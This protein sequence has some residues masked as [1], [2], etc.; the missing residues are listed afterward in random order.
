MA[1]FACAVDCVDGRT[2]KPLL[3]YMEHR[4]GV[5][6]VDQVTE[7][8]PARILA[9]NDNPH[10]IENIRHRIGISVHNH[11]SK[12]VAI[13]A[14]SQCAGNPIEK[15][16]QLQQ[17]RQAKTTI[18]SFEFEVEVILLW[19]CEDFESVEVIDPLIAELEVAN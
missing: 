2:T 16:H 1:K 5:D 7:P 4:Y 6:Y 17:L 14:H 9:H 13:V 18:D 12:V 15:D 19:I 11:G 3:K 10:V 8:G